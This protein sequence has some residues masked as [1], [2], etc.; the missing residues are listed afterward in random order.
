MFDD[1]VTVM[2]DS[3]PL[4]T[5][6]PTPV[7]WYGLVV[8]QEFSMILPDAATAA[9]L[10]PEDPKANGSST[11]N[12]TQANGENGKPIEAKV[13]LERVGP[14]KKGGMRTVSFMVAGK[15]QNVE[16]KDSVSG[17]DFTGPMAGA[18]NPLEVSVG[19]FG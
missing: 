14:A 19:V 1:Y 6:L 7:F 18:D 10:K 5:R 16:V 8:G 17:N 2:S 15:L 12:G 3:S 9:L 13:R 4:L 11:C